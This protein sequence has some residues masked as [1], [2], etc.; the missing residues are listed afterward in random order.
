MLYR[1]ISKTIEEY[2]VSGS[3]KIMLVEGA[4]QIGK[5]FINLYH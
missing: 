3:N 1:K 2:F 5:T 4:H